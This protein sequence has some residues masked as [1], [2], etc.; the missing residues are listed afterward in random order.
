MESLVVTV[1]GKDRPGLVESVSAVVE[2]HGGSWV[3]S[4]MS[5]LAGEFAGILRVS[6]PAA[7]VDELSE[8]LEALRSDGLRV[9]IERGVEEA[10]EEGHVIALELIGSDRPGIV[11]KISEALAARGV[12][13]EELN[14]ECDGAP[15]SGDTL[16]KATARLRAPR[17]LDLDQLRESLE[18]I[19]G[20]LM[21]DISIGE[22]D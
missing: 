5:R 6:V 13:V 15:W 12:N 17:T 9:V 11:H 14:T 4:R 19:A 2:E 1:I 8:A 21:V 10:V 20:D 16:F 22:A 18:A 7:S 3:E